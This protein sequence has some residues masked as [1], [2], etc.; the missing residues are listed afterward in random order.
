MTKSEF[1][2]NVAKKA[3]LTNKDTSKCVSAV[4]DTIRDILVAGDSIS[5][6]G[7]GSFVLR[8]HAARKG[9]NPQTG[10]P[11]TIPESNAPAFVVSK[12]L[13]AAVNKK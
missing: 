13:K 10:E 9:R 4:F 6:K 3:E 11:I 8:H 5:I 1:I 7:F 2:S 12:V